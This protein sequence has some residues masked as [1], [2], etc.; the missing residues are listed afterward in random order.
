MSHVRTY[1]RFNMGSLQHEE[2]FLICE[3]ILRTSKVIKQKNIL[4]RTDFENFNL[5]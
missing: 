5:Q 4:H 1:K 2:H 3:K